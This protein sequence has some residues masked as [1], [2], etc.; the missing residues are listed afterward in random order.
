MALGLTILLL[1]LVGA[2]SVVVLLVRLVKRKPKSLA[3]VPVQRAVAPPPLPES[4]PLPVPVQAPAAPVVEPER[5][6]RITVASGDEPVMSLA[7]LDPKSAKKLT[8]DASPLDM[9]MFGRMLEPVMQVAPSMAVAAK[10]GSTQLMEVV[11]NGPLVKAADGNGFRAMTMGADGIKENARLFQPDGLQNL[12]NA[13]MVWQIASVI[14]AQKHLADIS[15][16]LKRV[17]EKVAGVQSMLEEQRAALIKSA[18]N[19][20]ETTRSAMQKGEFLERTRDKLEDFEIQLEQAGLTL[21]QQIRR[22]LKLELEKDTAGCE[23]EYKSALAKHT[24]IAERLQELVTCVEVRLANWYLC[25]LY[26]D[27]SNML[28]GRMA[29][30]NRFLGEVRELQSTV[31]ATLKEDCLQIDAT[32]TSNETIQ[33]RRAEVRS[34]AEAGTKALSS[35]TQR[36]KLILKRVEQAALDHDT[37][38]RILVEMSDG[39]PKAIYLSHEK[40]DLQK[41]DLR[42][43]VAAAVA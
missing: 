19:Y 40:P 22:E 8:K 42:Q 10:A 24:A 15:K 27:R 12:A 5:P 20:I 16:T 14:V 21:V 18:L 23:G 25:S 11:I 33:K 36:C 29:Q 6:T 7:V 4:L 43:R 13:A 34:E 1:A 32:F 2:I 39:R 17:E 41:L 9:K 30:I 26:P 3:P 37:P 35:G 31:E 28:E 38:S